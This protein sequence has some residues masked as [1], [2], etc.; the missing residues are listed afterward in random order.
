MVSSKEFRV[1][2]MIMRGNEMKKLICVSLSVALIG[3][4]LTGIACAE[5]ITFE[6]TGTVDSFSQGNAIPVQ[7]GDTLKLNYTFD[8]KAKITSGS[9]YYTMRFEGQGPLSVGIYNGASNIYSMLFPGIRIDLTNDAPVE[10]YSSRYYDAYYVEG[11]K[12]DPDD[13]NAYYEFGL[14]LRD[15]GYSDGKLN[16]VTDSGRL[17]P[18][19]PDLSFFDHK[20]I[21][22]YRYDKSNSSDNWWIHFSI[23]SATIAPVPEPSTLLLL[24]LGLAWAAGVRRSSKK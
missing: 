21:G 1:D 2:E 7:K 11:T 5:P 19:P 3:I 14:D 23:D 13:Q 4:F 8:R 16:G 17:S 22:L 9:G 18:D 12:Q 20:L 24:G 6:F 10:Q 15:F